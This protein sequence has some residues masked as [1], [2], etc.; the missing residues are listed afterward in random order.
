MGGSVENPLAIS[1]F[2]F[3]NS[4]LFL[5]L[6]QEIEIV[7]GECTVLQFSQIYICVSI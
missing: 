3:F 4:L 6:D 1:Y 5:G 2:I 7:E